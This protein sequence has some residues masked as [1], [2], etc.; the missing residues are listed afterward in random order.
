[1]YTLSNI[2]RLKIE[3]QKRD[4]DFHV[5]DM[6]NAAVTHDAIGGMSESH[7]H[8]H[9]RRTNARSVGSSMS[10]SVNPTIVRVSLTDTTRSRDTYTCTVMARIYS[11]VTD[12]IPVYNTCTLL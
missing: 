10:G 4:L 6:I 7:I 11:A 9:S 1:M 5:Y 3:T 2:I 12:T 8:T